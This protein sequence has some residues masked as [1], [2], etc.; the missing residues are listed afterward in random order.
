MHYVFSMTSRMLAVACVCAL[1]L[2]VLLFL[3]GVEIGKTM[4]GV[5]LAP[6]QLNIPGAG[7]ATLSA[8]G[9]APAAPAAPPAAAPTSSS[10]P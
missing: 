6:V 10:H 3:L 9:P 2:C 4:T 5:P 8:P 1:A 7:T